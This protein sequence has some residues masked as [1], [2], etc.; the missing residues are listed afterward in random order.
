MH[1]RISLNG[2]TSTATM[3]RS[4]P[5]HTARPVL[6]AHIKREFFLR[7]KTEFI[8]F[9]LIKPLKRIGTISIAT[10]A[11]SMPTLTLAITLAYNSYFGGI[12]VSNLN[13]IYFIPYAQAAQPLWHFIDC[14]DSL[15]KSFA[16]GVSCNDNAYRYAID[17]PDLQKVYFAPYRRAAFAN[18]HYLN[19][20]A[21]LAKSVVVGDFLKL[22]LMGGAISAS[23]S[24]TGELTVDGPLRGSIDAVSSVSGDLVSPY[25]CRVRCLL[26]VPLPEI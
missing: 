19:T 3:A 11:R 15:V 10:T 7:L 21:L 13:R 24:C 12:Y 14:S 18:W 1:N 20:N 16:H 26:S 9:P 23:S 6:L 17:L 8:L 5:I 4:T 25:R 2:T 22:I